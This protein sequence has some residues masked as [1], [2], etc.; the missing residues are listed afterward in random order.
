LLVFVVGPIIFLLGFGIRVWAQMHLHYLLKDKKH[1]TTTGPY[2][3]VRNPI[4]IANTIL[5]ISIAIMTKL[6][7]FIPVVI[8]YYA[9]VYYFV[10][11]HEESYILGRY[12]DAYREYLER[13]PRFIPNFKGTHRVSGRKNTSSAL[14]IPSIRAEYKC[15]FLLIGPVVKEIIVSNY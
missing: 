9:I 5:M 6:L 8:F 1:L 7:W 13:V 14:L 12:K 3:Y 10:V 4:Y 2:A 11:R 15:F